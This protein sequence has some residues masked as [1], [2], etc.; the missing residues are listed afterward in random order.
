[1]EAIYLTSFLQYFRGLFERSTYEFLI[2]DD[3]N[4]FTN[5]NSWT[6]K[7][8]QLCQ[9]VFAC[10][11]SLSRTARLFVNP[12]ASTRFTN[13]GLSRYL[14]WDREITGGQW[15]ETNGNEI[16]PRDKPWNQILFRNLIFPGQCDSLRKFILKCDRSHVTAT[17]WW[18][19]RIRKL[20]EFGLVIVSGT[21]D[22]RSATISRTIRYDLTLKQI[23]S[24]LHVNNLSLRTQQ[25]SGQK[26][27]TYLA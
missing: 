13:W 26:V 27:H 4:A 5:P 15:G 14:H 20:N 17:K 9:S 12:S 23:P 24:L 21:F 10:L 25:T 2:L 7:S 22:K 16:C 1:M 6:V 19:Q 8:E 18:S 3:G 11:V